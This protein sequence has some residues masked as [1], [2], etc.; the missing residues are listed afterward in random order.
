MLSIVIPGVDCQEAAERLAGAGIAVRAG[1]HCAPLAHRSAGT[2]DSGTVR[3]SVSAL[4]RPGEMDAAA[5]A[6][7]H[8]IRAG[9]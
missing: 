3:L 6:L 2:L 9:K 4:N 7:R 5:R 1:L 8:M